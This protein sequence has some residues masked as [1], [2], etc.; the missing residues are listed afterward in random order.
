MPVAVRARDDVRQSFEQGRLGVKD[1]L[2]I[3]RDLYEV[4]VAQLEADVRCHAAAAKVETL[5]ARRPFAGW[6][7]VTRR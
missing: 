5:A 2:D 4:E 7:A 6:D 3:N 1:L